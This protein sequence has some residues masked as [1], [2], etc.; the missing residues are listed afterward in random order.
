MAKVTVTVPATTANLGAGFDSLGIALSLYN[1]F[2][3]EEAEGIHISSTDDTPI[4]LGEENLVYKTM[5]H[6]YNTVGKPFHGVSIKQTNH[7]PMA[8]GLGSSSSCIAGALLGANALCGNVLPEKELYNMA[9]ALEGHPDNIMPALLGGFV[10][11]A[12]EENGDVYFSK[13]RVGNIGFAV[14]VPNFELLTSSARKALPKET[15]YANAIF[16]LSHTGLAV[17]AFCT[18]NY[19]LLSVAC[20]DKI[21]QPY[22]LPLIKNGDLLFE[23]AKANGAKAV[24]ISGAGSSIMSIF[25][26]QDDSYL[27]K[28]QAEI[29]NNPAFEDYSMLVLQADNQGARVE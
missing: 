22:R 6:F 12:V 2:E 11:S 26:P 24:F 23:T 10:V 29:Q 25:N 16:N 18:E 9:V 27:A 14:F 19:D 20:E 28:M 17:A 13:H 8:R 3:I 4:P 5:L 15:S 21:H 1:T 7:I